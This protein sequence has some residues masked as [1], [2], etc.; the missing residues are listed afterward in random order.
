[1]YFAG[2]TLGLNVIDVERILSQLAAIDPGWVY[3]VVA[4]GAAVENFFPPVP[5]D[6]F[7]VFGAFLSVEGRVTE[8]G[9]FAVTWTTNSLAALLTYAFARKWG[10]PILATEVGRWLLRPRQL[11][12]LAALYEAHGSKIIF[13]SRFL[14]AFRSLVPFFAGISYLSFWRTALPIAAASGIWYGVL[15][16]L[17]AMFGRNWRLILGALNNVNA[18]LLTV[19]GALAVVLAVLW[20]RTRHPPHEERGEGR[21]G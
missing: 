5:A 18:L 16:V 21:G 19:A 2:T 20:Y 8:L 13:G 15:V 6:T 1:M 9:V 14:P 10:R 11:E 7:V 17:G 4:L 3:A 12:R